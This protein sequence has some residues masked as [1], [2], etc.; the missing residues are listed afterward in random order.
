MEQVELERAFSHIVEPGFYRVGHEHM[1]DVAALLRDLE[2][3]NLRV[4]KI[5]S[6]KLGPAVKYR[7]WF[8]PDQIE[9]VQEI[10]ESHGFNRDVDS[11]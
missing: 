10:V 4:E 7:G 5:V 1:G 2:G 9:R 6:G 11:E 8:S 3:F